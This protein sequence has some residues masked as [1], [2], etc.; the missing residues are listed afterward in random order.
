MPGPSQTPKALILFL[1]TEV[2][3]ECKNKTGTL[4]L[5]FIVKGD[6]LGSIT[7]LNTSSLLFTFNVLTTTVGG[8][9]QEFE[10][11]ENDS[12]GMETAKLLV[13]LNGSSTFQAVGELAE[14]DELGMLVGETK[15]VK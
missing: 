7:P 2:H 6:V 15:I 14:K 13:A 5:L 4:T 3:L 9:V 12:G 8:T 10:K 11:W 1:V